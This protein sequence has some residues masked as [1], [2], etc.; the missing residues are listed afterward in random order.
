M[1]GLG[2]YAKHRQIVANVYFLDYCFL[3]LSIKRSS[4]AAAMNE[5]HHCC[6]RCCCVRS[7][8]KEVEEKLLWQSSVGEGGRSHL[9]V[10]Q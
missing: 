1:C 7:L 4:F 5:R 9:N 2:L 3:K 10:P 6:G 8:W